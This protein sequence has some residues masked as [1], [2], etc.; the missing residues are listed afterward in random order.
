MRTITIDPR[1]FITPPFKKCPKCG[2]DE[3][4]VLIIGGR[5][6]TRR[7]RDRACWHTQGYDLPDIRKRVIYI[8]QFAVSNMMKT[9]KPDVKG[10]ER[11]ASE[12]FWRDLFEMLDVV[13]KLQLV[14]CPNSDE[15]RRESLLSPF[16]EPL[17]RL[18]EQFSHGVSFYDSETIR[19]FQVTV[20][21]RAWIRDETPTFEFDSTRVTRGGLHEWDD[22]LLITVKM[23]YDDFVDGIRAARDKAHQGMASVFA[24]W[25]TERKSFRGWYEEEAMAFGRGIV[26]LY[27]G[28]T[29]TCYKMAKGLV[30]FDIDAIMPTTSVFL[31][32][33]LKRVFSEAGVPEEEVWPQTIKFLTSKAL[34]DLPFN[35]ISGSLYAVLAM[36]AAAGQKEPP[37][38]GTI[39]DVN[40]VSTLLPYCDA[41]FI[42]NKSAA[43]LKDVPDDYKLPYDTRVFSP[44]TQEEFLDYLKGIK[45]SASEDHLRLIEE[46]YGSDWQKPYTT[47]FSSDGA[48]NIR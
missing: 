22:R 26:Q 3:F 16:Y 48:G 18:Y 42:D 7:C 41:M 1:D 9:L 4:G 21:A 43:L 5:R 25:Q 2:G 17:R 47:I 37:N 8:D 20:L 36:K 39:A 14:V 44:N 10:H 6:Y 15:H 46:V 38:R 23:K 29:A 11:A 40:I 27:V 24:R 28:W 33:S 34:M 32:T 13:C 19:H 35:R 31:I 12:P 45:Q 30:P